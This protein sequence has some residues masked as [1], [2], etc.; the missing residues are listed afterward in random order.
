[1]RKPWVPLVVS[2]TFALG[3]LASTGLWAKSP[4]PS[5]TPALDIAG[6]RRALAQRHESKAKKDI[7]LKEDLKRLE[8]LAA[9][10]PGMPGVWGAL[11]SLEARSGNSR[12]AEADFKTS[13]RL[14]GAW[15]GGPGRYALFLLAQGRGSEAETVLRSLASLHPRDAWA[16]RREAQAVSEL[17]LRRAQGLWEAIEKREPLAD[18]VAFQLARD[19]FAGGNH[20]ACR[21]RLARLR[22]AHPESRD[23]MEWQWRCASVSGRAREA[24]SLRTEIASLSR[25]CPDL[26]EWV[27]ALAG[28]EPRQGLGLYGQAVARYPYC[29][30][31]WRKLGLSQEA[32]GRP[33][34]AVASYQRARDLYG[35]PD[36]FLDQRL[37]Q[38]GGIR[39]DQDGRKRKSPSWK[40]NAK[41]TFEDLR[42]RVF[43]RE[44]EVPLELLLALAKDRGVAGELREWT[45]GWQ[46]RYPVTAALVTTRCLETLD[47]ETD[48]IAILRSAALKRPMDPRPYPVMCRLFEREG[49]WEEGRETARRWSSLD[50]GEGPLLWS[51]KF[52]ARLGRYGDADPFLR[53]AMQRHPESFEGWEEWLMTV[54]R[55]R[56]Q[57]LS[58]EAWRWAQWR[59]LERRAWE[60][61]AVLDERGEYAN[62]ETYKRI[63]GFL[64]K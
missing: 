33:S 13:V 2:F 57:D 56:P 45:R 49:R 5:P 27:E 35:A 1:M 55:L 7:H 32:A 43:A 25:E 37:E 18:D 23:V 62:A 46:D 61:L 14:S 44:E 51:G 17:D 50:V 26:V 20:E 10:A 6:F 8:K 19:A 58:F 54:R 47:Q 3:V 28:V 12:G 38:L 42:G 9:L 4:S 21:T 52:L 41:K 11:A 48:T 30:E 40:G 39:R 36:P 64:K 15:T 16:A 24:V 29:H 59:P 63:L 31:L 60:Q 22:A 34:E 53:E